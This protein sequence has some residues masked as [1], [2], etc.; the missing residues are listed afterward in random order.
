[1]FYVFEHFHEYLR[2][3]TDLDGKLLLETLVC[4]RQ[5][6]CYYVAEILTLV[7]PLCLTKCHLHIPRFKVLSVIVEFSE[8]KTFVKQLR[9][10]DATLYLVTYHHLHIDG[11]TRQMEYFENIS[12]IV[13][14]KVCM[15]KY[16][17]TR[18]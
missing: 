8:F 13:V 2:F 17:T 3:T 18:M 4:M 16:A 12:I 6:I 11:S 5:V 15:H 9:G 14:Y 1:M 7:A 10:S